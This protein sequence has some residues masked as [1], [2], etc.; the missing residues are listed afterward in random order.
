MGSGSSSE[1]GESSQPRDR[2][3]EGPAAESDERFR[4]LLDTLPYMAFV[5]GADGRSQH[6]NQ[7]FLDYHGHIPGPDAAARTAL[8]HPEDRPRLTA[9]RR[10]GAGSDRDYIVEARLRRHDGAYRWHRIHNVPLHRDGVTIAWLG[11]AVDI[12]EMR[13]AQEILE[14]RVAAR[15]AELEDLNRRL[16]EQIV[17][18]RHAEAVLKESEERYRRLYN[19]TPLAL[20][21]VDAEARLIDVNDSWL[22]LFGYAREEVLGRSPPEFMTPQ[23]ASRYRERA[24]PEL[25]GSR[26]AVQSDEFHFVKQTGEEF[27]GRIVGRVDFDAQG[28]FVRSWSAIADVT[29]EKRAEAQLRQAQKIEAIGQLTSGVAHDFNNLL[30]VIIGSIE[31]LER[32]IAPGDGRASRMLTAARSAAERG[33][34][35]TGQLLAFARKQR[36]VPK[37][38]DVGRIVAG[39]GGLLRSTIDSTIRIET[40]AAEVIW[41]ALADP[42]QLELVVL[43]LAI[44]ARD[45]MPRG[46]IITIETGNACLGPPE[47]P[48]EPHAGEYVMIAVADTGTGIPAEI[49]DRI[50]EPFFTTKEVGRGSGLGLPQVLGLSQQLGG[51]VRVRT[52]PGGGTRMEVYLPRAVETPAAPDTARESGVE[53][54]APQLPTGLSLMLVDDDASVRA[55]TAEMLREA[56]H[57]VIEADSAAAALER[58]ARDGERIGVM[59]VDFAMPGMN[60]MELARL[61]RRSRPGQPVVLVTGYADMAALHDVGQADGEIIQKPYHVTELLAAIDRARSRNHIG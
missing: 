23:S 1:R 61:A 57:D 55:I 40:V 60:G 21:S 32:R 10:D 22:Q 38:V 14:Q 37:P 26:G 58:L 35:L 34:R 18:R 45:A 20:Q 59:V 24:W 16:R 56:G 49:R 48:E 53:A 27:E 7:R 11:T 3:T 41:P 52:V 44:N 19:R 25:M 33:A 51:G 6:Y 30:T 43:N 13:H 28:R 8:L 17:E 12:D 31:L 5:I 39:M 9:A 2:L 42:T 36:L 29:V 15:T 46:G 47:R 50:F 4:L 54:H